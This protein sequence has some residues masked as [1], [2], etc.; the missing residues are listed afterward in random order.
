MIIPMKKYSFIIHHLQYEE[1]MSKLRELGVLHIIEKQRDE[2]ELTRY[3][4]KLKDIERA[5]SFLRSRK[6]DPKKTDESIELESL[7]VDIQDKQQQY[8]SLTQQLAQ[9]K[10]EIALLEPW[11]DFSPERIKALEDHNIKVRLCLIPSK[12][13][14][15]QWLTTYRGEILQQNGPMYYVA[16]V[17]QADEP[18]ELDVEEMKLPERSLADAKKEQR[19]LGEK[20]QKL[21][22]LFNTL[23]ASSLS[24]LE[25]YHGELKK[26]AEYHAALT[27]SESG[28]DGAIKILQGWVPETKHH[29]LDKFLEASAVVSMQEKPQPGDK[30]PLLLKNNK[31]F[32]LFEPI[33]KLFSLPDYAEID[34]TPFFAPFFALF[35]GFCLGDAGYGLVMIIASMVL[36]KRVSES[37]KPFL[38]LGLIL[39]GTTTFM[40]LMTGTFFGLKLT[41]F[42]FLEPFI[43][44][45]DREALGLKADQQLFYLAMLIGLFQVL[46]GMGM[47]VA[48][49]IQQFGFEYGLASA[50]K[51]ITILSAIAYYL[52]SKGFIKPTNEVF[53]LVGL[54]LGLGLILFFNDPQKSTAFQFGLGIWDLYNLVTGVF[55]DIL[56]YV[57][58]FAL[59][60]SS[61]ILGLVINQIAVHLSNIPIAGPVI[62]IVFLIVGHIFN[63]A[64][65]G[66]G[67]FVHP[68]RL[69]FVEF[70]KNV[71]FVGGG[72]PYKPFSS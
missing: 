59:G 26:Q 61:A 1:F 32:K 20:Q 72:K 25:E 63:L 46:F 47:N 55:G 7:L 27:S 67:A 5:I 10:K 48:N 39:G 2:E 68:V 57:R 65:S 23:A 9:V 58:L 40:G 18:F 69:T 51:M 38:V 35:F 16:F 53:A 41:E 3:F 56:S 14:K 12:K 50:G 62:F 29:D 33:G 54:L 28:L 30:V 45:R 11:G 37:L 66:L 21:D 44:I 6:Q 17:T 19:I 49:R 64:I 34:V 31:F 70:Y 43:I 42:A 13:F 8:E 52:S 22:T 36:M 4:N 15:E 24:Q 60:I 71:G